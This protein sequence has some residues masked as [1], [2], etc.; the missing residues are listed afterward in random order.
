MDSIDRNS[1]TLDQPRGPQPAR[2]SSI[3]LW[4]PD[5]IL[6]ETVAPTAGPTLVVLAEPHLRPEAVQ[7]RLEATQ[8]VLASAGEAG[9][10]LGARATAAGA[11][12]L[13]AGSD[14]ERIAA[15]IEAYRVT[16]ALETVLG[17]TVRQASRLLEERGM[18]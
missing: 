18:R 7:A 8:S 12:A 15:V 17:Q 4:R 13:A 9:Q 3:T 2:R 16:A 5:I 14:R 6:V 1:L 10:T 11:R